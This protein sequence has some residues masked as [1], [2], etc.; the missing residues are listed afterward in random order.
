MNK[1]TLYLFLIVATLWLV[2]SGHY[3]SLMLAFGLVSVLLVVFLCHQM[4]IVD[5]ELAPL[6]VAWATLRYLPWLAWE[7]AKSNLDVARRVLH[8]ALPID[9]VIV[10]VKASQKGGLGRVTYANSIT[11]TPGTLTMEAEDDVFTIHALTHEGAADL[12]DGRMD[13]K[14]SDLEVL[15]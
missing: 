1:P 14:V 6:Q 8:P 3:T 9:P 11:L 7:V 10:R 12:N 4:E 13:R 5:S 15:S 2:W